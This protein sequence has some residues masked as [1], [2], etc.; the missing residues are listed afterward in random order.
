MGKNKFWS[1]ENSGEYGIYGMD[2]A[3]KG[4]QR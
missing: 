3:F 4:A 1:C 2:D